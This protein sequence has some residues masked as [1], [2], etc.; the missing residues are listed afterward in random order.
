MSLISSLVYKNTDGKKSALTHDFVDTSHKIFKWWKAY[1][2][3][4]L[5]H[6]FIEA[7]L[8]FTEEFPSGKILAGILLFVANSLFLFSSIIGS[9]ALTL[10]TNVLGVGPRKA[11]TP[12]SILFEILGS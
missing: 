4:T 10:T 6:A 8:N 7:L 11:P 1:P 2:D 3:R 5:L 9:Q 12:H